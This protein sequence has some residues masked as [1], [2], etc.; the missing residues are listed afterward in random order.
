MSTHRNARGE[1]V[2]IDRDGTERPIIDER[3]ADV[4]P[5]F[6]PDARCEEHPHYRA[7][8]CS[9]CWGEHVGGIRP[10]SRIGRVYTPPE[11]EQ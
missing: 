7:R 3:A 11:V 10:L 5:S 6:S 1:Q 8:N 9:S 2:W 4:L